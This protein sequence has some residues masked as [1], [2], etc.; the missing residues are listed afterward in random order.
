MHPNDGRVVS[1]FIVQALKNNPITIYGDGSQTRSFCYV[2][3]LIDGMIKLMNTG[4]DITGPVN[5]GNPNEFTM[6]EL[7]DLI[8]KLTKS[9]S[10]IEYKPLPEDDPKQRRPDI[11]LA[12]SDLAWEPLVKLEDGLKETIRYFKKII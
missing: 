6:I 10:K 9:K 7:A 2:D 4:Q 1:N 8:L 3:D 11:S 12:K 5:I